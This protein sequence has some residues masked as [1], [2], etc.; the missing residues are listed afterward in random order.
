[1]LIVLAVTVLFS[2]CSLGE[3]SNLRREYFR[4]DQ[5]TANDSFEKICKAVKSKDKVA[6]QKMFSKNAIGKSENFN[7]EMDDLFGFFQGQV[8]SYND[9]GGPGTEETTDDG[10]DWKYIVSTYDVK[11]GV[12]DYRFAIRECVE[13][14]GYPDNVGLWS[15]YII[16]L[17]DD[18]DP[19]FAYRGDSK[20]TPGINFNI[21]NMLSDEN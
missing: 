10:R 3:Q 14:T 11:T 8:L 7:T 6:M 19:K 13:D 16:K 21:K 15:I 18:T 9:W 1:M 12:Q 17:Q 4:S 2:A 20:W 5:D